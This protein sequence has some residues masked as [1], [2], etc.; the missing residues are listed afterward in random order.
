MSNSDTLRVKFSVPEDQ[1]YTVKLTPCKFVEN[2]GPPV[3]AHGRSIKA[4]PGEHKVAHVPMMGYY[5]IHLVPI[6]GRPDTRPVPFLG[7]CTVMVEVERGGC[8]SIAS[9]VTLHPPLERGAPWDPDLASPL[10]VCPGE[11]RLAHLFD[12]HALHLHEIVRFFE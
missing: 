3:P 1:I 8:L 10:M 4:G 9:L 7:R 11:C 2:G 6:A 5:H 12:G